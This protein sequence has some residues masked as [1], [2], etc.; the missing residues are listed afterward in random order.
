MATREVLQLGNPVLREVCAPVEEPSSPEVA[1]VVADLQDTLAHWRATTG[2]GRGVAAPQIGVL[3][4]IVFLNVDKPWPL[5]NP[6]VIEHSNDTMVVWDGCLSF[7]CVF[8]Q[9]RRYSWISV[10]YQDLSGEWGKIKA[11][12]NLSELLQHE[13]D[14]LDGILALDRMTDIKTMCTRREFERRYRGQSPYGHASRQ[15]IGRSRD[16]PESRSRT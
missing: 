9:V 12:G 14:H 15:A 16:Q 5:I 2:Y 6:S 3:K 7:L 11:E 8:L 4:R 13:I 1:T 10:R